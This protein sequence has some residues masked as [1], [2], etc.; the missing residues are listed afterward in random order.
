MGMEGALKDFAKPFR[1]SPI[2]IT[3][4]ETTKFLDRRVS[5]ANQIYKCFP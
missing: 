1:N 5:C 2:A 4:A 3:I